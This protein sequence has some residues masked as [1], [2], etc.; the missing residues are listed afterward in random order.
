MVR[1][2][3]RNRL[4]DAALSV[5][6]TKGYNAT[7]V[8]DL[9]VAAG[10]TKG[11][12]F[13]HFAGKEDMAVAAASHFS[14]MADGLFAMLPQ[15]PVDD[16]LLRLLDYVDLRIAII[17]GELPHSTCL[18]GTMVQ[19]A[20]HSHPAIREA[21]EANI[22]H[23]ADK[24]AG[25]IR[26]A[27]EHYC[28]DA[29]WTAESLA[30][31]TQ[32]AIQGGFILAKA[33]NGPAAAIDSLRHL[34]RYIELLFDVPATEEERPAMKPAP[35]IWHDLMTTD[36]NAAETFYAAVVGWD[37][38]D[39]GMPDMNYR[40]LNAGKIGVGGIMG[41][42]PGGPPPMW[43]GYVYS[44]DVD[45]DAARAAKLG[46]TVCKTP[47]DIPGVGRFAVIADPGGAMINIFKPNSTESPTRVP[48]TTPGH[49]AWH[50][51]RA[52][53]LDSAWA[54][55]KEMFGWTIDHD[56]NAGP[57][58]TYRI[59]ATGGEAVGGM[60]TKLA[61]VPMAH[62]QLFFEIADGIEA[63]AA[64]ITAN[65]GKI[66]NGPMQVPGGEWIVEAADPQGAT[67]GL[68]AMKK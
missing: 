41:T 18:L 66:I 65:G 55:Y 46:G 47:E 1:G 31:F 7:T 44:A 20:F 48:R 24:V 52:G 38:N 29:P 51:L 12:F 54:F 15:R 42:V 53:D 35:F 34:R 60:M 8:D 68:G 61:H 50:D 21:C 45:A 2:N 10:V 22:R 32:A 11:A 3:S 40:V 63:G 16:P 9:C 17:R 27:R 33:Q 57:M 4:L 5:I 62:W 14:A 25:I 64:R 13:H 23:H 67:F 30:Q 56:M 28:P 39:G 43:T 36:V 49:V 26:E 37:I 58:G 6:R 59:F 19:E